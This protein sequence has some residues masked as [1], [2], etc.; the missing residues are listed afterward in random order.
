MVYDPGPVNP[1]G[2]SNRGEGER[3]QA[4]EGRNKVISDQ[5]KVGLN[6]A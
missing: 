4:G 6:V 1:L 2:S 5:L 3:L